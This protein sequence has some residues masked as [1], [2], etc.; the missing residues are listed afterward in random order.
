MKPSAPFPL[1]HTK[2]SLPRRRKHLLARPRLLTL[3]NQFLDKKLILITAPAGYGKT[4]LLV[5]FSSRCE[6]PV[7]WLALDELDRDPQRFITYFIAALAERFPSF[8]AETMA[9]LNPLVSLDENIES[10]IITLTNEIYDT[11]REHFILVLDD[12]HLVEDVEVIRGFLSRFVKLSD[13]SC[14]LVL[15]SRRLTHLSNLPRM[16]AD[17]QVEGLDFAELAFRPEEIQSLFAQNYSKEL[18]EE[19]AHELAEQSEGWI[20]GLQLA[21]FSSGLTDRIRVARAAGLDLNQ[22]FDEQALSKQPTEVRSILLYTSLF[23]EFDADLC[24]SV[25][26]DLFSEPLNWSGLLGSI[27][28]NNLFVLPVGSDGRWLRYHHLFREFLRVRLQE[29]HPGQIHAIQS[30][31]VNAYEL[32]GE[33]ERAYHIC[34]QFDDPDLL[35]GLIE[36]AGPTMLRRAVV[37]LTDWLNALPPALANS[38]PGLLSLRGGI[39]YLRG[40]YREALSL[41]D[42]AESIYRTRA[43]T[44]GLVLTLVRRAMAHFNLSD[45][46]ASL[47]DAEEALSLTQTVP[48][49]QLDHAEAQRLK[50]LALLRLG[51]TRQAVE[52]LDRSLALY[53]NLNETD[54]IPILLL[55]CGMAYRALGNYEAAEKSYQQALGIW[56]KEGN[57]AWQA[58][59]L[60]NLGF[61]YHNILGKYEKA[62]LSFREGLTCANRCR[63]LQTEAAIAI[64]MGELYA[65]L[66]EYDGARQSLEQADAI[67]QEIEDR[68]LL[69]YLSLAQAALSIMQGDMDRADRVLT[70]ALTAIEAGGSQYELGLW[71]LQRGRLALARKDTRLAIENLSKAEQCFAEDGRELETVWGRVWLAAALS[72]AGKVTDAKEKFKSLL[73]GGG[74]IP[75]AIVAS[76]R[77]ARPWLGTLRAD[78]SLGKLALPFFQQADRL[79]ARLPS[80]RRDLRRIPQAVT[81]SAPRLQIQSL[82]WTKVTINMRVAEWPTQ[83]VRELF[84]FFLTAQKPLTK[85][86]VAE[87]LWPDTEDPERIKQRFK[88]EL[89]RL[90]RTVGPDIILLDG[91]HYRFNRLL[92]YDH[93]LDDFETYL[94]RAR[95]AETDAERIENYEKAV[96]LVKGQYLADIGA[97]WAIID[98]ERIQQAFV[99]AAIFLAEL[100]WKRNKAGKTLEACQRALELEPACEPAHQLAMRAHASRGDRAAIARQYQACREE[101][102][103]LFGLPPTEE[104]EKLYRQLIA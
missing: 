22:Y 48:D 36:R 13:E 74:S 94:T 41:L 30:H 1:S 71:S 58:N 75:H 70:E 80:L 23:E 32:R 92:D 102:Q 16:I 9:A 5:D 95:S 56:R 69:N 40:N 34:R 100:Y 96:S 27:L 101:S 79:E 55:N 67:A 99:E 29:E 31:L 50:G 39:G 14:H 42:Q 37:T 62:N 77:L 104:T 60:N 91:E 8:G 24:R 35:A 44:P 83:S 72:S 89:Y 28:E 90:R 73:T 7:C 84:F 81:L 12:Y 47:R 63:Y 45:Y 61:L 66:G 15:S 20:T 65:E 86:Q 97:A 2:V 49:L 85:E 51:R 93:D 6:L 18:T 88:N 11:I 78:A 4:S 68:F 3:V 64:G 87:I 59:A 82:G 76:I 43:E 10:L 98:R 26:A 52:C 38:R 57:L 46:T 54:S 25:L 17:E 21:R 33:W 53:T 19:S 103:H